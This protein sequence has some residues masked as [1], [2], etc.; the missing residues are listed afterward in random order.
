MPLISKRLD[1][2]KRLTAHLEGTTIEGTDMD[3][4]GHVWR[5]RTVF[6]SEMKLPALSILEAVR[7]DD[8]IWTGEVLSKDTWALLIQGWAVDD[9]DNPTD[10]AYEL[11]AATEQRLSMISLENGP[12]PAYPDVYKLGKRPGESNY[13][14]GGLNLTPSVVRPPDARVS[15]TAF[16]YLPIF[17]DFVADSSQPFTDAA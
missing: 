2:L 3:L 16:F 10:P 13:R 5:G 17:I 9:R 8:G 6:G 7:Q 15:A 12:F 11:A 14:I 4:H 1:A